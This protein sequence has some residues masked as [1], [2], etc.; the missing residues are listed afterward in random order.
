[1]DLHDS[2][3][4]ETTAIPSSIAGTTANANAIGQPP[5]HPGTIGA[6]EQPTGIDPAESGLLDQ[7]APA[8]LVMADLDQAEPILLDAPLCSGFGKY[9]TDRQDNRKPKPYASITLDDIFRL[10]KEPQQVIK[11]EAQWFIP[12]SLHTRTADHQR[13]DGQFC[14]VWVDIDQ[15][16]TLD[17]VK[18]VLAYLE[19]YALIY[20]SR[21]STDKLGFH[22]DGSQYFEIKDGKKVLKGGHRW[23]VILPLAEPQPATLWVRMAAIVNDRF[24]GM[25]IQPDRNSER[26]N[27]ICYLPNRGEFYQSE[28]IGCNLLSVDA[29]ADELA[30]KE[31]EERANQERL[32]AA[33]EQARLK[34]TQRMA[35]GEKSP[36]KA[37]NHAY[38]VEQ[39]L[40]QYGYQRHGNR[41]IS[42]N[43]ESG[44]PGVT[45]KNHRWISSHASDGGIGKLNTHS[46]SGDA[47]DLFK[48][49]EHGGDH[50]AALKAAGA[51]FTGANGKT[52]TQNNQQAYR[53][54]QGQNDFEI[55]NQAA[56]AILQAH[57][58]T[59]GDYDDSEQ[60]E[61]HQSKPNG[62]DDDQQAD[63]RPLS[64]FGINEADNPEF[65]NLPPH[66][67]QPKPPP[68]PR[69]QQPSSTYNAILDDERHYCAGDFLHHVDDLH[70]LK[71]L[72]GSISA[73]T[74]LPVHTVF[75]I[76]LGVFASVACRKY[77]VCYQYGGT[78]PIGEY[79]VAEQ[80]SG[81]AKTWAIKV[82]QHPVFDAERAEI[83]WRAEENRRLG[84]LGD[85]EE[86]TPPRPPVVRVFTSNT[87]PEA[88]EETLNS[89]GGFFSCVSSEQ[90]LFNTLLGLSYGDGNKANNND[91]ILNGFDGGHINSIRVS[92][93]RNG[94]YGN[95]VGGVV[96]F[97]QAGSIEKVLNASNGTGV[98][99]RFLFIAENHTLGTRDHTKKAQI[100]R[101]W[102]D[103]YGSVCGGI[104]A[105]IFKHGASQKALKRLRIG[106]RGWEAINQFRNSIEPHLAD[107]GKYSHI[108]LRGAAAKIDMQIMK[109]G[110]N[111]HLTTV[112]GLDTPEISLK[113]VQAAIGIAN[114][115]LENMYQMCR[116]KGIVGVRAEYQ[117]ILSLFEK[118]QR[119]R[120]ER[121]ILDAKIK[122]KPFKDFTGNKSALIRKA[123][124]EMVKDGVLKVSGDAVKHYSLAQ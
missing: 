110:A 56:D 37:F 106:A 13:K 64:D 104:A 97:A 16:T 84:L 30:A 107:G 20:S 54:T 36:I 22:N 4:Q 120:T 96:M 111:L 3:T 73:A 59:E 7:P 46:C 109:I 24:Q 71:R 57:W 47:F 80:P 14:A 89:S 12:S 79:V 48:H 74:G 114:G 18:N 25:G 15:H 49:Y 40:E 116:D 43:S 5:D 115:L 105:D 103:E 45:V 70:L 67:D 11:D 9:H 81:A 23:R 94:Y 99:E 65:H 21:S 75:L 1:M 66:N 86:E 52:I 62:D 17:A 77:E 50:N 122:T 102:L 113:T 76:G 117:A 32:Q 53:A 90:G 35:Q 58:T 92:A 60:L 10:G 100:N 82:F 91:L 118:D 28:I 124:G 41:W 95:V 83:Q 68:T 44:N 6:S 38:P 108:A 29:I 101:A 42:P 61:A 85:G 27:Q 63:D 72:A 26:V 88:L 31:E 34:A 51:M 33:T 121:N 8:P 119:P 98:S 123:L 55:G 2:N 19:V 39:C 87:T 69:S 93:N 78:L 112:N